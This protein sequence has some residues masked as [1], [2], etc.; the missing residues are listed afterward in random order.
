MSETVVFVVAG[1]RRQTTS[2]VL[3][4]Y[5]GSALTRAYED[6][7]GGTGTAVLGSAGEITFEGAEP[8]TFPSILGAHKTGVLVPVAG[9][10]RSKLIT[11]AH[12]L[13]VTWARTAHELVESGIRSE[14]ETGLRMFRH[15]LASSPD[16][17]DALLFAALGFQRLGRSHEAQKLLDRL[18]SQ[19]PEDQAARALSLVVRDSRMLMRRL[20][21][22]TAV[23]AGAGI[24]VA[25]LLRF[26]RSSITRRLFSWISS[27]FG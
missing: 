21:S 23:I 20:G 1:D 11:D 4:K 7:V 18:I 25:V 2:D 8:A 15:V 26:R 12:A 5:P 22:F 27:L 6:V 3:R 16:D 19:S 14:I 10:T 17:R 13:G 24:A 9:V